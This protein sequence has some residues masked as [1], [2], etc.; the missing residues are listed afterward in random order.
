MGPYTAPRHDKE[1]YIGDSAFGAAALRSW[2][3][4]PGT[5]V[6]RC[7][8]IALEFLFSVILF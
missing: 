5:F 2:N 6:H 8:E 7:F 4:L 1:V 3:E